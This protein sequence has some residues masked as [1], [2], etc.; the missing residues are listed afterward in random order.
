MLSPRPLHEF[1]IARIDEHPAV[2]EAYRR[3]VGRRPSGTLGRCPLQFGP[4]F[5]V[6]KPDARTGEKTPD[7]VHAGQGVTTEDHGV[8]RVLGGSPLPFE[9]KLGHGAMKVLVWAAPWLHHVVVD[10]A[11]GHGGQHGSG[12]CRVRPRAPADDE[13]A[14]HVG[15]QPSGHVE[16]R[17]AVT[18]FGEVVR[19]HE[20][21]TFT[22]LD[23][24]VG[25]SAVVSGALAA[26]R[27]R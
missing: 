27:M 18:V 1:G 7:L 13:P 9:E 10:L 25:S 16:C 3:G 11:P 17:A 12:D 15:K 5:G 2:P 24:G 21:D 26:V 4:R 14:A 6:S 20:S 8:R 19:E 22:G 23:R